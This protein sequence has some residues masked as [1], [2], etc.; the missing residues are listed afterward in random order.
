[1]KKILFMA[2][3][4]AMVFV[5]A[6]CT[7]K[8]GASSTGKESAS[9]TKPLPADYFSYTVTDD[10]KGIVIKG[11]SSKVDDEFT[12]KDSKGYLRRTFSV[13]NIPSEIEGLPVKLIYTYNGLY[14][15]GEGNGVNNPWDSVIIPDGVTLESGSGS[16]PT[17]YTKKLILGKNVQFPKSYRFEHLEEFVVPESVTELG[18]YGDVQFTTAVI[19]EHIKEIPKHSGFSGCFDLKEITF[20]DGIKIDK[21]AY[22]PMETLSVKTQQRLRE[23][24]YKK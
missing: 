22:F 23:L 6:S 9:S 19:P 7:G 13:L 2:C 1:M 14:R 21:D 16:S 4:T 11:F 20:P 18:Y 8:E 10:G 12:E 24:G 17:I 3:L 5:G 15:R